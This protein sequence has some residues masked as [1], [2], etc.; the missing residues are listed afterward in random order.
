MRN[1]RPLGPA[2]FAGMISRGSLE[3]VPPERRPLCGRRWGRGHLPRPWPAVVSLAGPIWEIH[4]RD[5]DELSA[6]LGQKLLTKNADFGSRF[7]IQAVAVLLGLFLTTFAGFAI[8]DD[9]PLGG[10]PSA[11]RPSRRPPE[12]KPTAPPSS[13]FQAAVKSAP[14]ASCFGPT[15]DHYHHRRLQRGSPK[16]HGIDWYGPDGGPTPPPVMTG[17]TPPLEKSR[18]GMIWSWPTD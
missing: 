18:Y 9:N 5:G 2:L 6:P 10:E 14:R 12:T 11:C 7:T 8:F 17:I 1:G 15:K 3:R 4:G 13:R 16:R